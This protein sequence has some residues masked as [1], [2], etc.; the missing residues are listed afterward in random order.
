MDNPRD[1][2]VIVSC[3]HTP[4]GQGKWRGVAEGAE[5][6]PPQSRPSTRRDF[7]HDPETNPPPRE[8]RV[9]SFSVEGLCEGKPDTLQ[10][11]EKGSGDSSLCLFLSSCPLSWLVPHDIWRLRRR[12]EE[13][14]GRVW[15]HLIS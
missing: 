1:C 12:E 7:I 2:C 4:L 15:F 8:E 10:A 9:P 13:E 6:Q 14:E 11:E 3:F 5:G